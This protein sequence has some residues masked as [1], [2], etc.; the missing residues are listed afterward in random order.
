MVDLARVYQNAENIKARRLQ[1]RTGQLQLQ[2]AMK[3]IE[4][5]ESL[6]ELFAK[7]QKPTAQ[8]VMAIDPEAGFDYQKFLNEQDEAGRTLATERAGAI[9]R[10]AL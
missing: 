8:E 2:E 10:A 1:N 3:G 9:G 6:E 5:R 7:Q 4:R